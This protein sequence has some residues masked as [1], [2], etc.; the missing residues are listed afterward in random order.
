MIPGIIF[1]PISEFSIDIGHIRNGWMDVVISNRDKRYE[2][3]IS[4]GCNPLN[5]ILRM[6]VKGIAGKPFYEQNGMLI[7]NQCIVLH[8][9]ERDDITWAFY[10]DNGRMHITIW[11]D[12][13][14]DLIEDIY[15]QQ[16]DPT[17]FEYYEFMQDVDI[18][19]H[20]LFALE[21][22][23]IDFA[24]H[25]KTVLEN[26]SARKRVV[27]GFKDWGY[28]YSEKNY[29]LLKEYVEGYVAG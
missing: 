24:R 3:T 8:D 11:K 29:R 25:F 6:M 5:D 9:T 10:F 13:N 28:K 18:S 17:T 19:K 12:I 1:T 27:D 21:G 14:T 22:P 20:L 2:Y 16:F 7:G 15:Y 4:Y 23:M 26:L